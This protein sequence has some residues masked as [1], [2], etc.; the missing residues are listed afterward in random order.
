MPLRGITMFG[1]RFG[2][3]NSFDANEAHDGGAIF[4]EQDGSMSLPQDGGGLIFQKLR[5]EVGCVFS[6]V[7]AR[8]GFRRRTR[9]NLF[10]ALL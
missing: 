4:N 6:S 9:K 8:I 7:P 10:K 3:D 1:L 2:G 5:G